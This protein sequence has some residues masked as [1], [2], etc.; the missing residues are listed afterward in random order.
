LKAKIFSSTLKN[1]LAYHNEGVV[2]VK[3]EAVGLAPD[4]SNPLQL[5]S[6]ASAEKASCTDQAALRDRLVMAYLHEK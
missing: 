5:A 1:D 6:D 4:R 3:L 2:A